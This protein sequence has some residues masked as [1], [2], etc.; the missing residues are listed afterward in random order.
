MPTHEDAAR[1]NKAWMLARWLQREGYPAEK[2]AE[3]S[4]L[5]WEIAA[6]L[7]GVNMPSEKTRAM[8]VGIVAGGQR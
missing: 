3:W 7:A 1:W 6:G 8:A 5:Q 2:V 4:D